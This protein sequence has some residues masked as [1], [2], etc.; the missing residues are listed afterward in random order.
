MQK[1]TAKKEKL[2]LW[3]AFEKW[4]HALGEYWI[5][6]IKTLNLDE[7]Y[8]LDLVCD[9]D[10]SIW[11]GECSADPT[12]YEDVKRITQKG[13]QTKVTLQEGYAEIGK[14]LSQIFSYSDEY[15]EAFKQAN[16][17]ITFECWIKC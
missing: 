13:S 4:H 15:K 3:E 1:H 6:N 9:T 8:T 11:D 5:K 10:P 7:D 17:A 14:A 2:T 16:K 12:V